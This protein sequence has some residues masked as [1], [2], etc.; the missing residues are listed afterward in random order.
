MQFSAFLNN[1]LRQST[2]PKQAQ[3][4]SQPMHKEKN[5]II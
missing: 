4:L 5:R 3:S 2:L 1:E